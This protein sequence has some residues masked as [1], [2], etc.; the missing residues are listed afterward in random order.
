MVQWALSC[1]T[2]APF[3]AAGTERTL[4]GEELARGI[5]VTIAEAPGAEL[6]EYER[7]A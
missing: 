2:P 6:A 7:V 1:L 3:E 4:T 5:D